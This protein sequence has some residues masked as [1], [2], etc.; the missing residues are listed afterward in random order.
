MGET[1][2]AQ[3]GGVENSIIDG[4]DVDV[5]GQSLTGWRGESKFTVSNT[6]QAVLSNRDEVDVGWTY[7]CDFE[8]SGMLITWRCL[9]DG[10]ERARTGNG[11]IIIL[12]VGS[13]VADAIGDGHEE[14]IDSGF[15][16]WVSKWHPEQGH[17]GGEWRVY[18][19]Y[20]AVRTGRDHGFMD[21]DNHDCRLSKDM[22]A[23]RRHNER[24]GEV[25]ST[26]QRKITV[27]WTITILVTQV[28]A[29]N[30]SAWLAK[31]I[32]GEVKRSGGPPLLVS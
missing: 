24:Q 7:E 21:L 20:R 32:A 15:W 19:G 8:E 27:L 5:D 25:P 1:D 16:V 6:V 11:D 10:R 12:S 23:L 22:V 13:K 4:C 17:G 2:A 18:C 29:L 31:A 14:D 30:V 28:F 9:W 3:Q 26:L